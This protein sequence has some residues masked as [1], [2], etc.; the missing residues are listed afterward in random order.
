[1]MKVL[2]TK[3]PVD[4]V[5]RFQEVAEAQGKTRASLLK[6]LVEECLQK[7]DEVDK[8]SPA[9]MSRQ[10]AALEKNHGKHLSLDHCLKQTGML[11]STSGLDSSQPS[12]ACV[13]RTLKSASLNKNGLSV[14]YNA[15]PS[16]PPTPSQ[17][18]SDI[19]LLILVGLVV[20][21]ICSTPVDTTSRA[22]KRLAQ[23]IG[24]GICR[25]RYCN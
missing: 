7:V 20:L 12:I 23:G 18:S 25:Q 8:P 13:S 14:Y 3:L 21:I 11:T 9:S 2:S 22:P 6:R 15:E 24:A 16:R 4:Q 1:M 5:E 17:P 19:S 10:A